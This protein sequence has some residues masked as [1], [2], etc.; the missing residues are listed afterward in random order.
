VSFRREEGLKQLLPV[1]VGNAVPRVRDADL[2][3]GAG[4]P[5]LQKQPP[6]AGRL[7]GHGLDAVEGEV[8]QDLLQGDLVPVNRGWTFRQVFFDPD[9]LALR[10]VL[11]EPGDRVDEG[12]PVDRAHLDLPLAGEAANA[13]DHL[14]RT[15]V[16]PS[17]VG[18]DPANF[19]DGAFASV[20]D[21]LRRFGVRQDRAER[22]ID[23]VGDRRRQ[24]TDGGQ[25][26]DVGELAAPLPAFVLGPVPSPALDEEKSDQD[27]LDGQ[28]REGRDHDRPVVVPQRRWPEQDPGPGRQTRIGNAESPELAFIELEAAEARGGAGPD[29]AR[30]EKVQRLAGRLGADLPVLEDPSADET[31]TH[32]RRAHAHDRSVRRRRHLRQD[33]P[34]NEVAA[35]SIEV[36]ALEEDGGVRRE[37]AEPRLEIFEPKARQVE[38]LEP[39]RREVLFPLRIGVSVFGDVRDAPRP[40][41]KPLRHLHGRHVLEV[42]LDI[43]HAGGETGGVQG[44]RRGE[45]DQGRVGPQLVA[46]R[47][48]EIERGSAD[49]DDRVETLVG[50]PLAEPLELR[51]RLG[52]LADGLEV[53]RPDRRATIARQRIERREHAGRKLGHPGQVRLLDLQDQ[54]F[55]SGR[56]GWGPRGR[57]GRRGERG[58]E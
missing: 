22:L 14:A 7:R 33:L 4:E 3:V 27:G 9:V 20:E 41:E 6:P 42:G 2:D 48:D 55:L 49:G 31:V 30:V 37:V 19:V 23:L 45:Q 50:V 47:Q 32:H 16:V 36:E 26:S 21:H 54:D 10:L 53:I 18:E 57:G 8:D 46:E 17:D 29:R 28:D 52:R 44:A 12:V 56:G 35:A 11:E 25:P 1:G 58:K 34:G 39:P 5:R 24:L 43:G 51:G 13:S 38:K 40:R 15:Q